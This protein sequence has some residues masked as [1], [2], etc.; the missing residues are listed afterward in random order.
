MLEALEPAAAL[1]IAAG[2]LI[3]VLLGLG[4]LRRRFPRAMLVFAQVQAVALLVAVG[5]GLIRAY[6][7]LDFKPPVLVA[8]FV[9]CTFTL[10]V[11]AIRRSSG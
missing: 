9:F 6:H 8:F 10:T 7:G 1:A 4:A 5:I 11:G 2:F 3:L